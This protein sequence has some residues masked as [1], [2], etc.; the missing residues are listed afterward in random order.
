M[1]WS[2]TSAAAGFRASSRN[3]YRSRMARYSGKY[4]PPWR[5]SHTGVCEV[6]CL[7]AARKSGASGPDTHELLTCA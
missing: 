3:S 6:G 2:V 7:R 1:G 5:M 4:R